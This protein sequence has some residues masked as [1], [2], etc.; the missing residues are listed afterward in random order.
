MRG[1]C[2]ILRK[3]VIFRTMYR[4]CVFWYIA[5]AAI[6]LLLVPRAIAQAPTMQWEKSYGG[7]GYDEAYSIVQTNDGGFIIAGFSFSINGDVT[8]HHGSPDSSDYWIVKIDAA[9]A[10]QWETSLGGTNDDDAY[11]IVQTEDTGYI[12]AGDSYSN[13]DDVTGHHGTNSQSDCWI[14]KLNTSGV[15]QWEKS[16]GGSLDDGAYQIQQTKD[17]GYIVAGNTASNDGDVHG[18]HGASDFWIVKMDK[19]GNVVWDSCYGGKEQDGASSIEQTNDGGYIIAGLTESTDGEVTGNHGKQDYWVVKIDSAGVMQWE[20]CYG[21][22]NEDVP[23]SIQQTFDGGFIVAGESN[24]TDDEVTGN[25]GGY[26]YWIVKLDDTGKIQW[27]KSYGG[28]GDDLPSSISQTTDEGYIVAGI[29]RSNDGDV[30]GNHG[31]DDYWIIKIDS[32]GTLQ[33][34]QSYG[35]TNDEAANS[36]VQTNDNGFIIAGY[37]YSVNGDVTGHHGDSTTDDFWIV[38]LGGGDSA[39]IQATNPISA[40]LVHIDS[41]KKVP[42]VIRN[43][44]GATGSLIVTGLVVQGQD[45]LYYKLSGVPFLPDTILPGDSIIVYITFSPTQVGTLDATLAISYGVASTYNISIHGVGAN[46]SLYAAPLAFDSV[47]IN[48]C[49]SLNLVVTNSG[50]YP[51]AVSSLR[52]LGSYAG[53]YTV[54][55]I[56]SDTLQ[57][58]DTE[59]LTIRF[60][61]KTKGSEDI[62]IE[63][64]SN[65]GDTVYVN[66]TGTGANT[67]AVKE[68]NLTSTNYL[69]QNYPNPFSAST[70]IEYAVQQYGAVRLEVL[71]ALGESIATPVN[72]ARSAGHYTAEFNGEQLPNGIYFVRLISNGIVQTKMMEVMR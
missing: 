39:T 28:S 15:M 55:S 71:N 11:S 38:K 33:W 3:M 64:I 35:G 44:S 10:I 26:D 46:A 45:S 4:F 13:D 41:T 5:I 66:I 47:T 7:T 72:A 2:L 68:E 58:G 22:S 25:H 54:L 6:T 52:F 27:E 57:Q 23:N 61:P 31:G 12:I 20:K 53:D 51:L 16:L 42:F 1:G 21:G 14:V 56:P 8:G 48:Q 43:S 30:T 70:Q 29:S 65:A 32:I 67:T 62:V 9:G 69:S 18:N 60:C 19:S 24:S 50:N 59:E 63:L 37:S 34:E 49:K 17:S 40:G 36:I